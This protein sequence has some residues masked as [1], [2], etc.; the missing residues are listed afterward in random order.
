[1]RKAELIEY[2][3]IFVELGDRQNR[4]EDLSTFSG[5]LSQIKKIAELSNDKTLILLDEGFVAESRNRCCDGKTTLE[6]LRKKCYSDHN[7]TFF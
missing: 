2:E 4:E 6:F 1:M 3:D 5:H 7:H